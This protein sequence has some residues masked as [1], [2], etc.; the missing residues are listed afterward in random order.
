MKD[1][2]SGL[3]NATPTQLHASM[4]FPALRFGP[5]FPG[6]RDKMSTPTFTFSL[7]KT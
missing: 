3:E 1:H 4:H 6:P 5:S 2:I 7:T